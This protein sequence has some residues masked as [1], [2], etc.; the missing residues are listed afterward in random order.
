MSEQPA[1]T[2]FF[3][4]FPSSN[5]MGVVGFALQRAAECG[6]KFELFA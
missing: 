6:T 2:G 1:I 4:G 3:Q 5:P